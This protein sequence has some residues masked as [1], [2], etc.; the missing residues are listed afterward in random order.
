VGIWRGHLTQAS[1][2]RRPLDL[3]RLHFRR[4]RSWRRSVRSRLSRFFFDPLKAADGIG[5]PRK[6]RG[7]LPF[8]SRDLL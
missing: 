4:S 2:M 3:G 6:A 1:P 8:W 7:R 5:G